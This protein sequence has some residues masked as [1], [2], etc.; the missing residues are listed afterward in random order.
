M[1]KKCDEYSE[2]YNLNFTLVATAQEKVEALKSDASSEI[3]DLI[4]EAFNELACLKI[5]ER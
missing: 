1:R 2:K 5:E 4:Q 3:K